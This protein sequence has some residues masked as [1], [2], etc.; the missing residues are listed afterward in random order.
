MF[1]KNRPNYRLLQSHTE[2]LNRSESELDND[3]SILSNLRFIAS[4]GA[5]YFSACGLC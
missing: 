5:V 2:I 1:S 4:L 3:L